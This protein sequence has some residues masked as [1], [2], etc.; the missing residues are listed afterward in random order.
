M[1]DSEPGL[2]P[3]RP[4]ATRKPL[5]AWPA[6]VILVLAAGAVIWI[7]FIREL[8]FQQRN[9]QT[10][11]VVLIAFLLLLVWCLFFSRLRWKLRFAILGGVVGLGLLCVGLFEIRGVS[12][13][14][15][16]ILR[17]RWQKP[18]V[19]A[20]TPTKLTLPTL[21]PGAQP[22]G[23]AAV[24]RYAQFLGPRRNG[25]LAGPVLARDWK[26]LPPEKLWRQSIGAAWSGFAVAGELAVTQE[27]RGEGE[28]VVCY[29]LMTGKERWSHADHAHYHTTI[30]GEGPRATPTIDGDRV[31]S[32]G[33]TGILNC[34]NLASGK[35]IWSK[36]IIQDNHAKLNEWGMSGSPLVT[37]SFVVVS[38]GGLD[39][40]SLVAYEKATGKFVWGGGSDGAGY[41]SPYLTAIGG[42]PQ[43]LI[44]NANSLAAHDPATGKVLWHYLWPGG[45]PHVAMPVVMPNDRVL[46][47]SG[48]GTGSELLQIN[49]D[50]AGEWSARRLWKSNRLKAKFTNLIFLNGFIYGLDDGILVCLAAATGELKWKEGRYGHGQEILV[51]DLL[52]LAAENGEVLLLEPVPQ[53]SR[54]LTRF[55]SLKG[56][57]WNPP[58]LAGPYLLVRNDVE[59][60]CYR[61]PVAR[62]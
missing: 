51:G 3:D 56:K 41:S 13:D 19:A 16:P 15:L 54:V 39:S 58:A 46:V 61:L 37:E 33:A 12:G 7:R 17:W 49:R 25:T 62:Q 2:Q 36:N 23:A 59:A 5:R 57:T 45:H 24:P 34:L 42:T 18:R 32:L 8:S 4:T 1:K 31:Y 20:T 47:S 27:Q 10:T 44:F 21:A 48:Y 6:V 38:P 60:A 9:I 55:Q 22:S 11:M 52:L 14:L 40:R 43:I 53:E 29:D 50:G 30:A 26:S 28:L 35:L